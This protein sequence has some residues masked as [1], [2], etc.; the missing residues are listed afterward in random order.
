MGGRLPRP[1]QQ[2]PSQTLAVCLSGADDCDTP[3]HLRGFVE[4]AN[5][6]LS[7]EI[8]V[9]SDDDWDSPQRRGFTERANEFVVSVRNRRVSKLRELEAAGRRTSSE[10]AAAPF[11]TRSP[12]SHHRLRT[13]S[14]PTL[15]PP[16]HHVRHPCAVRVPQEI[17]H[18]RTL[19]DSNFGQTGETLGTGEG[20]RELLRWGDSRCTL[21]DG[22]ERFEC[23]GRRFC[24]LC[25]VSLWCR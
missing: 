14:T 17:A 25:L 10:A 5:E 16:R 13:K 24:Y 20:L 9:Y 4:R 7:K 2:T 11:I 22:F 21:L 12:H 15:T 3:S 19:G 6:S 1:R 23:R 18:S 8:V